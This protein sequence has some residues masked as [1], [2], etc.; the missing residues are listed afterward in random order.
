M[1]LGGPTISIIIPIWVPFTSIPDINRPDKYE[2]LDIS[3]F[4]SIIYLDST[5]VIYFPSPL[6]ITLAASSSCEEDSISL[7]GFKEGSEFGY[8]S[9]LDRENFGF[10]SDLLEL[11]ITENQ[12]PFITWVRARTENHLERQ[13]SLRVL[14]RSL[15]LQS[16]E[17]LDHLLRKLGISCCW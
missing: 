11:G 17:R 6:W 1:R 3:S 15:S 2:S 9:C 10:S 8:G 12:L 14:L 7:G 13:R 16:A 5:F 4:H